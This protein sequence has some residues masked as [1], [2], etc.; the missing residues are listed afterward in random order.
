MKPDDGEHAPRRFPR[1]R[2]ELPVKIVDETGDVSG[3][4]LFDTGDLS[5]GG[6][7]LR[8]TLLFELDEELG[9]EFVLP[10]GQ[11]IRAKG[12]V[13]RVATEGDLTGMGIAFIALPEQDRAAVRTFLSKTS[14]A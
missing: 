5:V 11:V 3:E 13:V 2:V 8:S 4:I 9:L 1:H 14:H 12:R 6:A 10:S 7:F